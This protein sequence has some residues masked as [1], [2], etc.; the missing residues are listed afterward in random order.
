MFFHRLQN[1]LSHRFL[2]ESMLLQVGS[3]GAMFVQA[4]AGVLLARILGPH[5]FGRLAI[6]MSLAAVGSVFLGAG[7]ADA[8]APVLSRARHSGNDGDVHDSFLFLGKF[9]TATALL[10]AMLGFLLPSIARYF[11]G[12][13]LLGWLAFVVLLA[14]A[15]STL[16]FVPTQLGLQVSG[17]IRK[18]SMLTFTDQASR[19][20]LVLFFVFSGFG[21]A[22]AVAGHFIGALFVAG[23]AIFFWRRLRSAWGALPSVAQLWTKPSYRIQHYIRPTLWVLADRNLAMLYGAAPIAIA[24]LYLTTTDVSYFKIALGWVTLALS[25]L[26]PISILLNTELARI[27]L[28]TPQ[29]LRNRFVQIS[30]IAVVASTL[31]TLVA[32][33][34]ARPLFGILYGG[35]YNGASALVYWFLP[36]GAVMGLGIAL[37]PMW[38]ALNRV[39]IS[40][41]INLSVLAVC[42]P[43]ALVAL[44]RWGSLGAIAMVTAWYALSHLVS[45]IYLAKVLRSPK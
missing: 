26:S 7:A 21:I 15:V 24:G 19:Q 28:Q 29:S 45:F 23:G 40:I 38:R 30:F 41:A 42:T 5:E 17:S 18:L 4:I 36:F 9:V 20:L 1:Y 35:A 43:L 37:G 27:Q 6:V 13:A 34:L 31:L 44:Q 10:V 32:G 11:Y 25:V 2:R 39:K 16:I 14:S 12:D 8:M 33:M 22:G 3:M